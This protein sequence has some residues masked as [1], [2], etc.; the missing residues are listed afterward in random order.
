MTTGLLA[1]PIFREHLAGRMHPECPARYDAVVDG[2]KR[3]GL[4]DR[5]LRIE[6]RDASEEELTLCHTAEYLRIARGDVAAGRPFLSTGDTDITPNSWEVAVRA[7]GGAL[8]AVDAVL[9]G[10]RAECLLRG[11]AARTPCQCG[12][13]HGLLPAE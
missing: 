4:A 2:L 1:D 8:N 12:P 10:R 5:M 7:A 11:E 9:T 6:A 3:A 13:R